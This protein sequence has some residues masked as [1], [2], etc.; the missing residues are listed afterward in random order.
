MRVISGKYRGRRLKGPDDREIRPT[1]DRLKET[2]FNILGPGIAGARM[3]DV[4]GGTGAV[5]I[6]ALSRGAREVV[7]IESSPAAQRLI[8][9]NIQICGIE[10]G[11]RIL[12]QDAF[13]ALRALAREGLRVDVV[14]FDPPYDWK[15]YRDLLEI[16][17]DR[18]LLSD[19][20]R[21]AIEHYRKALLPD[22]GERYQKSRTV[23]Q[24]DHCLS[25]YEHFM[26]VRSQ[27][28]EV[29]MECE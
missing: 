2:L 1:G 5:G 28:S 7:F 6:E 19:H 11:Y 21:A 27:E 9:R 16:I 23:R 29:R 14:F 12:P 13:M 20:G 22:S 4:F 24:G 3:L 10:T 15:P 18:R 8:L 17:F 25:F 26:G